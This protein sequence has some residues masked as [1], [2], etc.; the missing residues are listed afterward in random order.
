MIGD[1]PVPVGRGGTV[2]GARRGAAVAPASVSQRTHSY[3]LYQKI[4]TEHAGYAA[5]MPQ[6]PSALDGPDPLP[7]S[8]TPPS[9]DPR[10]IVVHPDATDTGRLDPDAPPATPPGASLRS[11]AA[12]STYATAVQGLARLLYGILV[13][14]LGSRELFGQ[15]N[16]SLSLSV[17]ASQLWGAPASAAGTRFVAARATLADPEGAAVVARHLATRTARIALVLPT[18]VALIGSWW[19]GFSPAHTIG[20]VVVAVTYTMYTTLRGIQYGQLRFRQVAV[21]DT[22]SGAL[23]LVV[24]T[25]VL[26]L[27]LPALTLL[28]L[29]LGYALF[30]VVSWPAR[31]EG[32]V[33][34]ALR[35]QIDL[36][37]L[38]GAVS[39]LATG[40]LLQLSQ[41]AAH[42]YAGPGEAGDYAAALNL[43]TPASMLSLALGTVLVPP[44]VA[45]AG[46]GDRAAVH[47]QSD[48][49][50]RRLTA[51][52]VGL[53]GVLVIVSPL[54]IAVV[55][56]A[57]YAKAATV[58]PILL[59]AVMLASIALGAATTL[60]STRVRGPRAVA[61]V[62]VSGL[63]VSL[64]VWPFLAPS[65]GTVGVALGYLIGSGLASLGM[66]ATVWWVERHHWLDLAA[67]LVGGTLVV[68][69]LAEGARRV[70][71]PAGVAAQLGAAAAFA[72]A[73]LLLNRHEVV[74]LWATVRGRGTTPAST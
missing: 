28:P 61:M 57:E 45:A 18:T 33:D 20:T 48:A 35:R 17:L 42:A 69:V 11:R 56:G 51:I 39:G 71:G 67:K 22:I 10:P 16:T 9:G 60:V 5:W 59:V 3:L 49:I 21:W 19:L 13:G 24:V 46:R 27:D 25:V 64:A 23:A 52:F 58:L 43:A 8:V 34:P 1:A 15:T 6:E 32:R 36:F 68:L 63:V 37:I 14:H 44:L 26:A 66:L 73:W 40:G 70:Q 31:A 55:W 53:F 72:V 65:H 2:S 54:A 7:E 29:A 38:F 12:L 47:A 30:A 4:V 50:A 74:A 41:L 62:N